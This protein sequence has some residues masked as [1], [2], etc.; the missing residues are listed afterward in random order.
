LYLDP[1]HFS[2]Y[3][4]KWK[5]EARAEAFANQARQRWWRDRRPSNSNLE[6]FVQTLK[7]WK[8]TKDE[9]NLMEKHLGTGHKVPALTQTT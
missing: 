7:A 3:S 2:R 6:M 8:T 9:A 1:A 5:K 4:Q